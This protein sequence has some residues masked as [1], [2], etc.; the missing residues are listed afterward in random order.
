MTMV[1]LLMMVIMEVRVDKKYKAEIFVTVTNAYGVI[2]LVIVQVVGALNSF[3]GPIIG[4]SHHYTYTGLKIR[5]TIQM[6]RFGFSI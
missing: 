6:R 2:I 1:F 3:Q 5:C 4:I